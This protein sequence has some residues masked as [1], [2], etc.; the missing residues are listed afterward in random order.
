MSNHQFIL[1][2]FKMYLDVNKEPLNQHITELLDM[3]DLG[4]WYGA[5]LETWLLM[6]WQRL[7]WA[8]ITSETVCPLV[9]CR[10]MS[11][12]LLALVVI[13]NPRSPQRRRYQRTKDVVEVCF[14]SSNAVKHDLLRSNFVV[15]VL[16][17]CCNLSTAVQLGTGLVASLR[18]RSFSCTWT[19]AVL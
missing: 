19:V 12:L 1:N 17:L 14:A 6:A 10:C 3:V 16:V 18:S 2:T 11:H 15:L 4:N 5:L 8:E 7:V 13:D 9:D